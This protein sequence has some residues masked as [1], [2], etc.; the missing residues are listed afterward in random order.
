MKA[1]KFDRVNIVFIF[2]LWNKK[3]EDFHFLP[4]QTFLALTQTEAEKAERGV[5]VL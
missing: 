2:K 3:A 4:L 1:V 5:L